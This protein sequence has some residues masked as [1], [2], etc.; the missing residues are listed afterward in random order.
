MVSETVL[1]RFKGNYSYLWRVVF[2]NL[3]SCSSTFSGTHNTPPSR[4]ADCLTLPPTR[5]QPVAVM[6]IWHV[7]TGV[8]KCILTDQD[9]YRPTTESANSAGYLTL[10]PIN[11]RCISTTPSSSVQCQLT[12]AYNHTYITYSLYRPINTCVHYI[13]RCIYN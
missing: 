11:T 1:R 7:A 8:Y 6:P 5:A 3:A 2:Q 13:N 9:H 10:Q 12:R 4:H